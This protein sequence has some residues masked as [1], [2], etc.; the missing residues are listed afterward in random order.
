MSRVQVK[1]SAIILRK[2]RTSS[3]SASMVELVCAMVALV[4]LTLFA[5]N[6]GYVIFADYINDAACREAARAASAQTSLTPATGAAATVIQSFQIAGGLIPSPVLAGVLFLPNP[7][8]VD[9]NGAPIDILSITGPN[10]TP[11]ITPD[12]GP[13][14]LVSTTMQVN[15]PAPLII[16]SQGLTNSLTLT[17]TYTFPVLNG[18]DPD[19]NNTDGT[20]LDSSTGGNYSYN[21]ADIPPG[22]PGAD[23]E[24]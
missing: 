6:I 22:G 2:V 23:G 12:Q 11:A 8:N 19:P 9:S 3:G 10:A 13:S 21:A 17:S 16:G 7:P 24:N 1:E 4:P 20:D 5:V 14:V 18:N 15:V